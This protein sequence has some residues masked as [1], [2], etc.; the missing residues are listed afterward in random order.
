LQPLAAEV[1]LKASS[2][3]ELPLR[4]SRLLAWHVT[5]VNSLQ[6]HLLIASSDLRDPN[7]F[8][9]IVLIVR[10]SEDGA[11]GLVLNRPTTARIKQVWREVSGSPCVSE[12][13]LRLGGPVEGMLM[14]VHTQPTLADME[15][16]PGIYYSGDPDQLRELVAATEGPVRFYAGYA[17]WGDGQ[18]EHEMDEGSWLTTPANIERIFDTAEDAWEKLT[19]QIGGS[20]ILAALGIKHVP[21]DP[22]LN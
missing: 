17:G 19:K 2:G 16:L 6:G 7:F 22:S 13:P 1:S 5:I 10:H 14:A 20:G 9:S 12:E 21:K 11:L 8:Q 18:L 4:V 3:F 15:V